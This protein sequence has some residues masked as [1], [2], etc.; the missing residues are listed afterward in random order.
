VAVGWGRWVV[1]VGGGGGVVAVGGGGGWW[2]WG[3]GGGWWRW[4]VAVSGDRAGFR[5]AEVD[6]QRPLA[7]SS[8]V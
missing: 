8:A 3:G 6:K 1:A 2:R 5:G 4:V 7:A